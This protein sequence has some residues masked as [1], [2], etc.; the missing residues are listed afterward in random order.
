MPRST[1]K[2]DVLHN[3]LASFY[4]LDTHDVDERKLILSENH[5]ISL[6]ESSIEDK[7]FVIQRDAIILYEK[8]KRARKNL[9]EKAKKMLSSLPNVKEYLSKVFTDEESSQLQLAFR[10]LESGNLE[11]LDDIKK[12]ML[13]L[14]F[15]KQID[16]DEQE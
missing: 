16:N 9:Y 10:N 13:L 6:L 7:V 5:N 8:N 12:E 11:S 4:E 15:I 14:R 1:N 2:R 3:I